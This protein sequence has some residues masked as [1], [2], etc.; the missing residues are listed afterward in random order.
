MFERL[1]FGL[2]SFRALNITYV[3]IFQV[4]IAL[5]LLGIGYHQTLDGFKQDAILRTI[6]FGT[7]WNS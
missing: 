2:I 6:F 1:S 7:H 3:E 5:A 4:L